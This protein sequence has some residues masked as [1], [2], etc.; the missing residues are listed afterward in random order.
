[1]K[2][3]HIGKYF[4]P[5]YG[6]IETF[7]SQLME[8]QVNQGLEVSA[9]VH[10]DSLQSKSGE[11]TWK[12]C[13]VIEA[14]SYGQFIFAPVSPIYPIRLFKAIKNI[15][16]DILHIH[17]PNL[18]AFWI[19]LFK[20]LFAKEARLIIHWHA[21]VLG[22]TPTKLVRLC[23]PIYRVFEVQ[24]LKKADTVIATSAPYMYSSIPLKPF[25]HKCEVIPLGIKLT[26]SK[27]NDA[28]VQKSNGFKMCM[29]GRLVYY[30]GHKEVLGALSQLV[31]MGIDVTLDIIGD[32]ELKNQLK[33]L[34]SLLDLD[35]RVRWHGAASEAKKNDILKTVDILLLPSLERTEAF[36]VVLLEAAN[37][38]LPVLVS[39]VEGS[40]MSYVVS[41]GENGVICP[42]GNVSEL[43]KVL[44]ELHNDNDRLKTM[45]R[46][47]Y[48]RLISVFSIEK[49]ARSITCQYRN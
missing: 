42:T 22:S 21:D 23:Y 37:Y 24:L 38:K 43:V 19:I 11:Y 27:L 31:E 29:L 16:P 25:H 4:P 9:L 26:D 6:G 39:D 36:G 46:R 45:G 3:L 49:V 13:K 8:E 18:S 32:G 44:Q 28:E 15:K 47:N 20:D 33:N 41:A 40:G 30:K 14:K 48:E 35:E 7:M 10:A 34:C 5:R 17:M 12:G 1:M 2:V